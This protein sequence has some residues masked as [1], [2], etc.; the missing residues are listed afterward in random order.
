MF[1]KFL[2]IQ[3]RYE[4]LSQA[5]SQPEVIADAARYQA[6]LK[7]RAALEPQAEAWAAYQAL[8]ARKK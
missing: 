1:D 4:E 8:L 5:I 2:W 3:N 7:E 6:C